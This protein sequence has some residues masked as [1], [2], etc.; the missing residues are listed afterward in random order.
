MLTEDAIVEQ[1]RHSNT[2]F[3]ELEASHHRLDLELNELQKRH[4]LTPSEEIEKKRMQKEKLVKKD[5]L[6]E[7]IR[8]HR[9]HR[10]EPAR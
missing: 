7:L 4:V 8:L 3:R 10:L 1:L 9:E 6:A 2:E 5:K